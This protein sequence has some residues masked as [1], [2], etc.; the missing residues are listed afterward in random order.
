LLHRQKKEVKKKNGNLE[1][2]KLGIVSDVELLENEIDSMESELTY[3][4][5]CVAWWTHYCVILSSFT[6]CVCRRAERLAVHLNN[7]QLK[8]QLST[9]PTF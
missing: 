6:R 7:E 2:K 3:D 9:E 4:T 1:L 5:L 8:S